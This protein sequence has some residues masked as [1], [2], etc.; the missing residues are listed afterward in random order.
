[1]GDWSR[2][3]IDRRSDRNHRP[4][5]APVHNWDKPPMSPLTHF[6]AALAAIPALAGFAPPPA[7]P[8]K[9][10]VAVAF[11]QGWR[12]VTRGDLVSARHPADH[13]RCNRD[14]TRIPDSDQTPQAELDQTLTAPWGAAEWAAFLGAPA[15]KVEL[16]ATTARP[17]GARQVRT[18]AL[19]IHAGATPVTRQDVHAVMAVQRTPGWVVI[20][21]CY[22][23]VR[24][25][26][27]ERGAMEGAVGSLRVE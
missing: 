21:A 3:A 25:Y 14:L 10:T 16:L 20:A 22:A 11:P 12:I 7:T 26:P 2:T 1:M 17:A 5:D 9:P 19:L 4:V 18:A 6:A 8:P 24:W 27:A 13:A 15:G 23:P